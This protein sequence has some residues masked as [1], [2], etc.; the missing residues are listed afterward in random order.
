MQKLQLY[1]YNNNNK[2]LV[3]ETIDIRKI[4][5]KLL[6]YIQYKNLPIELY[7]NIILPNKNDCFPFI[8]STF[9][10]YSFILEGE[11]END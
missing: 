1:Y 9:Q 7:N 11:Y 6:K 3:C 5:V 8:M 2:I 4:I 10:D